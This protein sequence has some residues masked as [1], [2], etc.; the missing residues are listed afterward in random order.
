MAPLADTVG[1]VNYKACKS[2]AA[3]EVGQN[4][5]DTPALVEHLGCDVDN[6]GP[7]VGFRQLV[8]SH[9]LVGLRE[10]A[11]VRNGRNTALDEVPRLVVDERNQ[12]RDDEC[13]TLGLASRADGGEL[14]S[15]T[16]TAAGWHEDKDVA[17]GHGHIDGCLL[18]LSESLLQ[19]KDMVQLLPDLL[20]P[21]VG[22][23]DCARLWSHLTRRRRRSVRLGWSSDC[24]CRPRSDCSLPRWGVVEELGSNVP[25]L[26]NR[27]PCPV[28]CSGSGRM[29]LRLWSPRR[30]AR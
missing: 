10:V 8:V 24:C 20:V 17:S 4:R 21:A 12:R 2:L 23:F 27:S 3:D 7:R 1:F 6:L 14:I 16:L 29:R 9:V 28:S 22:L 5:L 15:Q 26:S 18:V 25:P 13:D 11:S 19:P 30:R